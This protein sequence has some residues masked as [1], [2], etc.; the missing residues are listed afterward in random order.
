M[1]N[2]INIPIK[3]A[4]DMVPDDTPR[5]SFRKF[6]PN[7]GSY[8]YQLNADEDVIKYTGDNAFVSVE[9]AQD[10]LINYQ[11]YEN[12][13]M[14]RW[15]V[16]EKSSGEWLGWC[17]LSLNEER[18]VDIGFRFFQKHWGKGYATESAKM[19]ILHGFQTLG[20]KEI[21]GRVAREN[22]ASIKVL[23]KLGMQYWKDGPCGHI[24][25]ALYYR[26][27]ANDFNG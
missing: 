22:I 15:V 27:N 6:T 19:C 11:S 12:T 18:L 13:G 3:E 4:V 5:L 1:S 16:L 7:D 21:V 24:D 23:E 26:I 17:G 14:G 25:L 2:R 20:L 8:M 10:F 9:E